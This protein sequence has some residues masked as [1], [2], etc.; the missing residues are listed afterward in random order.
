MEP[1]LHIEQL[2][3]GYT[4]RNVLHGISFDVFPN[5]IVGLI[6]LNGAGKSTTIKHVIGLMQAK[7][8]VLLRS[9]EKPLIS[10]KKPIDNSFHIYQKCLFYMMS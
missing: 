7:K 10:K 8:K 6:G 2:E 1:L 9:M 4:H 3:G 5:E